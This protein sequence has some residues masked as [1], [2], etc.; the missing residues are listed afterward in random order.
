[1]HP[2]LVTDPKLNPVLDALIA[3]EPIFHHP[4]FGV[5][6][7]DFERMTAPEFWEVG[8]SGRCYSREN[9]L[10]ILEQRYAAPHDD[11]WEA[12]DFH[13]LELAPKLY[14]LTYRLVQ[15]GHRVTRRATIWRR[16]G[17]AWTIVYHQGTIVETAAGSATS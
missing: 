6:R 9:V 8:A 12:G 2:T 5:T 16:D 17:D 15:D 3:R 7:A 10:D 11:V 13:C 14:L 1:M 4:G